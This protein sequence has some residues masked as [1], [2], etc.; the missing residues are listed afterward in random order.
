MFLLPSAN[1]PAL[2][3]SQKPLL[4]ASTFDPEF[5]EKIRPRPGG[6]TYRVLKEERPCWIN[7]PDDSPG[8]NTETARKGV[9]AYICLPMRVQGSIVGVL[10]IHYDHP[11]V[12]TANEV[13][14][15][16]H[17]ANEVSAAIENRRLIGQLEGNSLYS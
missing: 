1:D 15:L 11:H 4:V 9:K 5:D 14:M 3:L 10:F 2:C 17:F 13:E 16:T 8:I 6:L 7:S 12:F